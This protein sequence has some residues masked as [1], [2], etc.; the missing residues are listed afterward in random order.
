MLWGRY[1]KLGCLAAQC[2]SF[3]RDPGNVGAVNADIRPFPVGHCRK[4]APCTVVDG[5]HPASLCAVGLELLD[6]IVEPLKGIDGADA[7][8]CHIVCLSVRMVQFDPSRFANDCIRLCLRVRLAPHCGASLRGVSLWL[9]EITASFGE[10]A[11]TQAAASPTGFLCRKTPRRLE[12]PSLIS[13]PRY[14]LR[15]RC[16]R[17]II[18]WISAWVCVL[19]CGCVFIVRSFILIMRSCLTQR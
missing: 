11:R 1:G 2:S 15:I 12:K 3:G 19:N 17:W 14:S 4:L 16:A 7:L 10:A 9:G 5:S 18:I 6:Q 13:L 8:K